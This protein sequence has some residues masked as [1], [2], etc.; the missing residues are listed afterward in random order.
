MRKSST[1][2]PVRKDACGGDEGKAAI[3]I[4]QRSVNLARQPSPFC[5]YDT[6]RD[7]PTPRSREFSPSTRSRCLG[8]SIYHRSGWR[9]KA[10]K[11][12]VWNRRS[13][14][15]FLRMPV[16][17]APPARAKSPV[18]RPRHAGHQRRYRLLPAPAPTPTPGPPNGCDPAQPCP[19]P[20]CAASC[21][22]GLAATLP[23]SAQ[24]LQ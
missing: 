20:K 8:C 10:R 2:L 5:E 9:F 4:S 1:C 6:R 14:G 22:G 3:I 16:T 7:E 11:V 24:V 17:L 13:R 23:C 15:G 12:R 18:L 21:T 19:R